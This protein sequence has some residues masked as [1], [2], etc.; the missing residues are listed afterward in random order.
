MIIWIHLTAAM[1][2]LILGGINLASRKGT[3]R[4]KCI[5]WIWIV[6]MLVV[7]IP[8]FWIREIN[9]GQLSWIH[10]LTVITLVS[11]LWAII[12]I[13]KGNIRGHGAAMIGT[14]IGAIIAGIFALM[15]GRFISHIFGYG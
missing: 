11:M 4:H 14:M 8:S 3:Y 1:A 10:G 12:A 7:T 6:I 13:K 5:G 9:P 15:P 2:A